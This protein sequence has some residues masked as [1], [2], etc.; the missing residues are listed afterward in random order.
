MLKITHFALQLVVLFP[1]KVVSLE[2]ATNI[3]F[4]FDIIVPIF[5]GATQLVFGFISFGNYARGSRSVDPASKKI[6]GLVSS[7]N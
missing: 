1:T 3:I 6:L 7:L 2:T 4:Y 5:L